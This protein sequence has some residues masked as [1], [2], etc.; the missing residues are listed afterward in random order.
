MSLAD[1]YQN[2]KNDKKPNDEKVFYSTEARGLRGELET[3][4]IRIQALTTSVKSIEESVKSLEAIDLKNFT[5]KHQRIKENYN[6]LVASYNQSQTELK[7]VVMDIS[8][9]INEVEAKL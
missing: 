8:K 3:L 1:L 7:S 6:S 2:I 5:E 9:R 4:S